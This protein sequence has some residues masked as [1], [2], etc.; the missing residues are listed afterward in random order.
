MALGLLARDGL[1]MNLQLEDEAPS[2]TTERLLVLREA[3]N[4]FTF[5]NVDVEPVPS[6]LRGFSAPVVLVDALTDA[7][8]LT[9]LSFDTD[10]FNRWEAGQRLALKRLL[11]AVDGNVDAALHSSFIDAMRGVLRHPTL[12]AAFKELVLTLPSETYVAEQLASVDPQRIHAARQALKLE[13]AQALRQDLAWAFDAHQVSGGYSPD[14]VSSGRRALANLGLGMLCLDASASN[15]PLWPGRAYQRF[16]DATNMTERQG[17][18]T[19]LLDAHCELATPA[20]QRFHAMF[21]DE[22]L[23][24]D[25]WF[26]LQACAAEKDGRVFA[27]VKL[28]LAHPDF[29]LAN[30]N[31]ARSLITSLCRHNPAAFHRSDAAGYV[32]WA[33]RVLE[34][35]LIN[36]KLAARI[37]RVMDRWSRLAEPYRSAAREAIARVAARSE[38]SND[39]REIVSHALAS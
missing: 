18:L 37:A 11:A 19:A 23:V 30:P 13:M 25:K 17:A 31:R 14:P 32:F 12:D 6:L 28:L 7:D 35:D 3:R 9:L 38:L 34:L 2:S 1:A 8:L 36:P 21:K 4:F 22:P 29:T 16:K 24:L 33:K 5:V 39:V 26:A 10:P 27:K 20:L 15:D